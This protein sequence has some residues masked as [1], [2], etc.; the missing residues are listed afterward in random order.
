MD[1]APEGF[2][3]DLFTSL[4][5]PILFGGVPRTFAILN[6]TMTAIIAL[7]LGLPVLGVPLGLIAHTVAAWMTRRDPYF[8]EILL[9][10]LRQETY[11]D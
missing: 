7:P 8:F 11:W 4:T 3:I 2:E 6:G 9:R 10:H 1:P 5:Q